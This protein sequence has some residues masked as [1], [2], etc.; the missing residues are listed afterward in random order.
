MKNKT[1]TLKKSLFHTLLVVLLIVS[2]GACKK[3]N[4]TIPEETLIINKFIYDYTS[5]YYLWEDKIPAGIN[6]NN[7]LDSY[8]LFE[9][10]VYRNLDRWSFAVDN[11]QVILDALDG[12][13]KTSGYQV[14]FYKYQSSDNVFAV[15]EYVYVGSP[16]E[17]AGLERG[18]V[19]IKNNG[20]LLTVNNYT[21]ILYDNQMLLGLGEV[22]E[23][24]VTDLGVEV[25]IIPITVTINPVL[26][27]DVLDTAG[28][29]IGYLLYDQFIEDFSTQLEDAIAYLKSEGVSEF[30]LDLRFNPGGYL[31]TCLSLASMLAPAT[32]PGEVFALFEWNQMY[33]D[34]ILQEEGAD[35]E[36][37][38][39]LFS[40][41]DTNLDLSR[42]FVLTSG[43]SASASEA[44]IN[45][46][47]PYMDVT[48]IGDTTSGKYTG[49]NFIFDE[50]ASHNWGIYLVTSKIANKNG[51]TDFIDGFPPE[52]YIDDDHIV[53]LGDP[54]EP[55]FSKAIELITG[56]TAKSSQAEF[57]R[58]I[59]LPHYSKKYLNRGILLNKKLLK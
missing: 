41:T 13:E 38:K 58:F 49:A 44:I 43:K 22:N 17:S 7:Y 24:V 4:N 28:I 52:F 5:N 59:E 56:I 9:D 14:A 39:L 8:Q 10:M 21:D 3:D 47:R 35:S 30:V 50:N 48:L 57:D 11:Y 51:E 45:G 54:E 31:T 26:Q 36:N 15:T 27:Y 25:S 37:L 16:A 32:S 1:Y 55:L 53:A 40:E 19:I 20:Q 2:F 12:T 46:L 6:I 18:D 34:Y 42:L 33:H 23:G 29:K